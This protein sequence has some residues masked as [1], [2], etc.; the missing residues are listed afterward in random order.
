MKK[1]ILLVS[2]CSY[3]DPD[4]VSYDKSLPDEKAKGWKMW[5]EIIGDRNNLSVINK[6]SSGIGN[7][8]IFDSI[9]DELYVNKN[10]KKVVV[11][12]SGWDRFQ[13]MAHIQHFPLASAIDLLRDDHSQYKEIYQYQIDYRDFFYNPKYS[14]DVWVKSVVNDTF[15]YMF[16]L[17]N[18][19][20]NKKIPYA[21]YQGVS[22]FPIGLLTDLDF[23]PNIK[24][25]IDYKLESFF[26]DIMFNTYCKDIKN[27]KNIIGFPFHKMIGGFNL[28][29]IL[30]D[31][32][33]VR[34]SKSDVH[35]N[36]KGQMKFANYIESNC[37]GLFDK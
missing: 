27:N 24:N 20:E 37:N 17:A 9:V 31:G 11:L 36:A 22:A 3:T 5:P 7:K 12:W 4:F 35:P 34:V 13:T 25:P 32:D 23:L 28:D 14:I 26:S 16:L 1:D 33:D 18:M 21:F 2:G 15:R 19:L 10:I 29:H 6:A 8:Q 30:G